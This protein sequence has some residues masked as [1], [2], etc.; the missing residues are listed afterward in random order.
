VFVRVQPRSQSGSWQKFADAAIEAFN[1]AVRLRVARGDEAVVDA[2]VGAGLVEEMIAGG[3]FFPGSEAVGE[4]RA[5]VR[6]DRANANRAGGLSSLWSSWICRKTWAAGAV[7]GDEEIAPGRFVRDATPIP[8]LP[9]VSTDIS[10]ISSRRLGIFTQIDARH[11]HGG[12]NRAATLLARKWQ[13]PCRHGFA[14]CIPESLPESGRMPS[15]AG[16]PAG[17]PVGLPVGETV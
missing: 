1:H 9:A 16:F 8:S 12:Q 11:I 17:F 2:G 6:Q 7:D 13:V 14:L 3:L 5:V 10:M 15:P 4:L